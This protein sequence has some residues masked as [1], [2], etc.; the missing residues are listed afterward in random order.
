LKLNTYWILY[1]F[2][3]L[4]PLKSTLILQ[5]LEYSRPTNS[6]ADGVGAW[7]G[8]WRKTCVIVKDHFQLF[9]CIVVCVHNYSMEESQIR[10]RQNSACLYNIFPLRSLSV[11]GGHGKKHAI[12]GL[13]VNEKITI[14]IFVIYI[15]AYQNRD[16]AECGWDLA[17][18]GW[19]LAEWLERLTA[20]AVG[21]TDLGSIPASSRDTLESEGRQIKQCWIS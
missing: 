9:M 19:D 18:C 15:L 17:E 13:L 2:V 11:G 20:N 5:L 1:M 6:F 8:G 3:Y 4:V 14:P 7:G 10:R 12:Q 16:L 21:A